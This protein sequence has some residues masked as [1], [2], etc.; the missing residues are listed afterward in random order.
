MQTLPC[1][2]Y[3]FQNCKAEQSTYLEGH[4]QACITFW[5]PVGKGT[6][7]SSRW[8]PMQPKLWAWWWNINGC[9]RPSVPALLPDSSVP[10]L[11]VFPFLS[12][13]LAG[14]F[15]SPG[16]KS[17][18]LA[19]ILQPS[20]HDWESCLWPGLFPL[21]LLSWVHSALCLPPHF[22]WASQTPSALNGFAHAAVLPGT[23]ESKYDKLVLSGPLAML[24]S[25]GPIHMLCI[26]EYM[27]LYI[28][29]YQQNTFV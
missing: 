27:Q 19:W 5:C 15:L 6:A 12:Y 13:N 1:G 29:H 24:Y 20:Y 14:M 7:S 26:H 18:H 2:P 4:L 25:A 17:G 23:L 9:G 28:L 8:S 3:R 10:A 16:V 22:P 11:C 21:R